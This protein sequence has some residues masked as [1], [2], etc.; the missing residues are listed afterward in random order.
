MV[1]SQLIRK[2]YRNGQIPQTITPKVT[3]EYSENLKGVL[4]LKTSSQSFPTKKTNS[5]FKEQNFYLAYVLPENSE[6]ENVHNVF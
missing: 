3:L 5:S 2:L 1:L 4:Q 6:R